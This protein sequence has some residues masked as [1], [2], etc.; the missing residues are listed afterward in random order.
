MN[1]FRFVSLN[2]SIAGKI[3]TR[4][5]MTLINIECSL[6][7]AV[8]RFHIV[9]NCFRFVSLKYWMQYLYI[10]LDGT[11]RCELLSFCIFEILNAVT[12]K[13]LKIG[14]MLWIAFV[15]YLWNIECSLDVLIHRQAIVVNCFRFVSL[16]YWMQL[17][18]R[19]PKPIGR[20][21]LLSFC[22]FEILNAV[23]KL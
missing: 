19:K 14:H 23:M 5:I 9:V 17:K 7:G 11:E 12:A 6:M 4:E 3:N 8:N 18:A 20:C 10:L 15:L 16:K 22:I 21:E 13:D 2:W 1:C